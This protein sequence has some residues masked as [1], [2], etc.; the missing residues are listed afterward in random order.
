MSSQE[1]ES[2]KS[3]QQAEIQKEQQVITAVPENYKKLVSQLDEIKKVEE[4][5]SCVMT[6]LESTIS[7][8]GSPHFKDFWE[9]KKLSQELFKQHMNPSVRLELWAKY[10]ELLREA[11]RLKEIFDEETA[12]AVEQI[13]MAI[14]VVEDEVGHIGEML[15]LVPPFHFSHPP[16]SLQNKKNE[17]ITQQR[18]LNLYNV[19]AAKVTQLRKE[20][21]K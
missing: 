10:S 14:K 13:E 7:Q 8:S 1:I 20:L 18:E 4:K 6:F 19:Y 12:F 17:Y 5:L 16:H 15:L 3:E 9:A 11:R 21:Q 2:P